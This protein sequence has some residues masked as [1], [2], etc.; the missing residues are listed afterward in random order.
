M[1]SF[2][3]LAAQGE[4]SVAKHNTACAAAE[5]FGL[6]VRSQANRQNRRPP[7]GRLLKFLFFFK[8]FKRFTRR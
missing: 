4:A 5:P 1:L 3:S 7:M 6:L 8:M 2:A